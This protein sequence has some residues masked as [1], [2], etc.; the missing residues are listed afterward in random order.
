MLA[1]S[2]WK[3]WTNFRC[4][5]LLQIKA[6]CA[7]FLLLALK[8]AVWTHSHQDTTC[9]PQTCGPAAAAEEQGQPTPRSPPLQNKKQQP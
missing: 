7:A 4:F 1:W 8:Q 5:S 9:H 2:P 3:Q 6:I